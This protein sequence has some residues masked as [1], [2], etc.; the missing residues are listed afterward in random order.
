MYPTP[1]LP[2]WRRTHR[3]VRTVR[4]GAGTR[5]SAYERAVGGGYGDRRVLVFNE[6][7]RVRRVSDYPADWARLSAAAL[8]ALADLL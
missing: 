4:L 8:L 6:P 5:C 2:T 1:N 3:P 7:A